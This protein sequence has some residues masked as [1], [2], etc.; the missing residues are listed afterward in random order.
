MRIIIL[1]VLLLVFV[2]S[3]IAQETL[4]QLQKREAKMQKY[5]DEYKMSRIGNNYDELDESDLKN[6]LKIIIVLPWSQFKDDDY[7]DSVAHAKSDSARY[8]AFKAKHDGIIVEF[9]WEKRKKRT[10]ERISIF[11]PYKP[12][13]FIRNKWVDLI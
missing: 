13:S 11:V 1:S 8:S 9:Q 2:A 10:K 6:P 3:C 4:E 12:T 7:I 5:N